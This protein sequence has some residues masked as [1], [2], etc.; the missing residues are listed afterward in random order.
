MKINAYTHVE[1]PDGGT[2]ELAPG[3]VPEW[4][5]SLI[6]NP[7][8]I[9]DES[10]DNDSSDGD[11]DGSGDESDKSN[12]SVPG[13]RASAKKWAEYALANGFEV[14]ESATASQI[15]EDLEKAGVPT[16]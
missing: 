12:P 10:D 15:R 16:E 11:S 9:V 6:T 1:S 4:A 13:K 8:L 5:E 7:S 2:K 14:D 3:K